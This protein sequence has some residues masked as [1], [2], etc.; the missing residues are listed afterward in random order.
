MHTYI[1]SHGLCRVGCP[2][3]AVWRCCNST[4]CWI[5]WT[6]LIS[7]VSFNVMNLYVLPL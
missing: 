7:F 3:A 2:V 6:L 4:V 5:F 1:M